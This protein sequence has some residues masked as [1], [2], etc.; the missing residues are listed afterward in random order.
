M[1]AK[2]FFKRN[3]STILTY[4]GCAGVIVT[5]VMAIKATPKAIRL[6]EDAEKEK[7][8]SLTKIEV[9]KT[10]VPVYIL[11]IITG[12]STIACI[13][14]ANILNK[15]Q[16]VALMSAYALLDNSYKEY[17]KKVKELYG[18][19][20]S[21]EV[22][23]ELV[24]EKYIKNNIQVD[25]RKELFYDELSGRYFEST[26]EN[27]LKAEYELNRNLVNNSYVCL[28]QFYDFL[29]IPLTEYGNELGWCIDEMFKMH[30]SSWIDFRHEKVTMDDGLECTI[31][32][33]QLSPIVNYKNN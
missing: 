16:Q 7:N 6:L 3:A 13:F 19:D 1:N 21:K 9:V 31:I 29:N 12:V 2:I 5:S 22:C 17:R 15:S 23:K 18:A 24:K 32:Y 27:V 33:I 10:T 8:E 4:I 14:G 28:N 30:L 20:T 25:D 11:T 26:I